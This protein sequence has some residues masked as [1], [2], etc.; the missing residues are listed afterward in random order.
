MCY[1]PIFKKLRDA[2]AIGDLFVMPSIS[3]PFGLTP[4]EAICYGTPAL[5]SKQSGVSEV[6]NNCLK[7]DFW[8]VD[9]MANK[10]AA[11][12]QNDSLRDELLIN[13]YKE[14]EKMSWGHVSDKVMDIYSRHM[15]G[16]LA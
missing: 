10:I 9:E 2:C 6:L 1:L 11:V 13:S 15:S 7:V 16:A 8:D 4:L 3:E 5:V 14:V 12:M